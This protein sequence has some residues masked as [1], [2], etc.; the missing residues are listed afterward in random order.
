[1][2]FLTPA[3][4]F[5]VLAA[6]LPVALHLIG[7]RPDL[8]VVFPAV[9]LLKRAP[10]Q[11]TRRRRLRELLLLAVRVATVVLLAVAFARPYLV[12]AVTPHR[13][14]AVVVAVDRSFS[15][16]AP[17]SFARA[18]SRARDIVA[19]TPFGAPVGLVAF[20]DGAEVMVKPSQ[21]RS[22]V[23]AALDRLNPGYGATSYGTALARAADSLGSSRGRVVVITD[24]QQGGWDRRDVAIPDGIDIEVEDVGGPSSN[25]SVASLQRADGGLTAV[26]RN[27]G[28]AGRT[29]RAKLTVGGQVR[30]LVP[31]SLD[32]GAAREI[33]FPGGP[34][35]TGEATVEIDD[36]NGYQADNKTYALLDPPDPPWLLVITG[37][38]DL[39]RGAF[40][41]DRALAVDNGSLFRV[42]TEQAA[43]FSSHATTVPLQECSGLVLL[44]TRGLT[45]QAIQAI[46]RFVTA[47]GGLLVPI[48]DQVSASALAPVFGGRLAVS[49]EA[50]SSSA[51]AG[52]LTADMRHPIFR[53]IEAGAFAGARFE[54][55]ARIGLPR[56]TVLARFANGQPAILEQRRGA[57]RVL[58]FGS[59]LSNRWNDLP[60]QPAFL[61][62]VHQM[63]RYLAGGRLPAREFLVS[64]VPADVEHRPGV[65]STRGRDAAGR[66]RRIVV[67]VDPRESDVRRMTAAEFEQ[68]IARSRG[69]AGATAD[70]RQ[71]EQQQGLWRLAVA[72]VVGLLLTEGLLGVRS[73]SSRGHI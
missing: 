68:V 5:G 37:E 14:S 45:D 69:S 9:R 12:R 22:A 7:R 42:E 23:Q 28:A 61:P 2:S 65:V 16:S 36:P 50:L 31:F 33:A 24:L 73:A 57:G 40:Y 46:E 55:V 4:L 39:S 51:A 6:A 56:A 32:G 8:R 21:D 43:R 60:L 72:A 20:D 17:G 49:F 3:F 62:L 34:P 10:A 1:M 26:V 54:R 15:M 64:S 67:N 44:G 13:A 47:G 70:A 66:A 58:V 53:S 11:E 71:S 35:A 18:L 30:G 19:R 52:L 48:D 29:G 59:D 41:L 27:S 63:A 25:L 38:G